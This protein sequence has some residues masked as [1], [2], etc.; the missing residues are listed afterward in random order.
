M[1]WPTSVERPRSLAVKLALFYALFF[2]LTS[3]AGMAIL[4]KLVR[5]HTLGEIDQELLK[6]KHEIALA[7][8]RLGM[9]ELANEFGADSV[10]Y[11]RQDYF[12]RL[13]DSTGHAKVSSDISEWPAIPVDANEMA[14]ISEG[15][16]RYATMPLPDGRIRARLF[17]AWIGP[18]NY[19]IGRASC[20]ERVS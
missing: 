19:Q 17:L 5:S 4:Y 7:V 12:I 8:E 11:G 6:R 1:R 10:A 9:Q 20:R 14:R 2:G 18:D 16:W 3:I 13:L 15:D